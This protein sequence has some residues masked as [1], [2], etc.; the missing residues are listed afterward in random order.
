MARDH[1]RIFT[2]IWSDPDWRNLTA[3]EQRAY[4][5]VF[6]DPALTYCGVAPLTVKRWA[7]Q[8]SDTPERQLRK[9]LEGLHERRY[10]VIDDDTEE[11]LV[12]SFM[13]RDK[14]FRLPNVAKAAY[15]AYE[16]VHSPTLRAHALIEVHRIAEG[17]AS[18]YHAK[19]FTDEYVGPWLA[20]P[21]PEGL[22]E[23]LAKPIARG[24]TEG[25]RHAF[26]EVS[27][28]VSA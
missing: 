8:A 9:V 2:R 19:A 23:S 10:L 5:M 4:L 28:E 12:R 11:V 6:S 18:D 24:M 17:P 1:A 13:R 15:A 25:F 7:Q 21:F 16:S 14:V 27:R 3:A 20:E 26:R 22:P